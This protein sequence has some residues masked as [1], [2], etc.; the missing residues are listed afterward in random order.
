MRGEAGEGRLLPTEAQLNRWFF[1]PSVSLVLFRRLRVGGDS[2]SAVAAFR[3]R[4]LRRRVVE[5]VPSFSPRGGRLPCDSPQT[6]DQHWREPVEQAP[7]RTRPTDPH[8]SAF[9]EKLANA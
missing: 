8:A 1:S 6:G 3:P 5:P 9:E 7:L 4:V 2:R